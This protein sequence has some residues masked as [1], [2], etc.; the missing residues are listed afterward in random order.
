MSAGRPRDARVSE[1]ILAAVYTEVADNGV[2]GLTMEAVARRA[3]VG[4]SALYRRWPSKVELTA[5]LLRTLSVTD[6][7]A[8]DTG[9]LGGDVL[10]LLEEVHAWLTDP[11]VRSIYPDLLAEAQRNP[12]LGVA[13]MD[14]VGRPRRA[15][16]QLVL[17]RAAQRGELAENADRELILDAAAALVFWRVIALSRP[18]TR[19]HL[20][21]VASLICAMA[22]GAGAQHPA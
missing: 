3:G 16:A 7:P 14:Q 20:K 1:A 21:N 19:A 17:E 2:R 12:A 6:E 15:R 8:P 5:Y 10:V 11:K 4:K 22:G 13:L 18:V 9:T